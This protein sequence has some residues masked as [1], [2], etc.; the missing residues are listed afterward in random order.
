MVA[1]WGLPKAE[2]LLIPPLGECQNGVNREKRECENPDTQK[3][4][5][6]REWDGGQKGEQIGNGRHGENS[7]SGPKIGRRCKK[8]HLTGLLSRDSFAPFPTDWVNK[9]RFSGDFQAIFETLGR[10]IS[11]HK[12]RF[13]N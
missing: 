1:F 10:T 2:P 9:W 7:N 5:H 4:D 8:K 12:G 13:V 6:M 11:V 3:G